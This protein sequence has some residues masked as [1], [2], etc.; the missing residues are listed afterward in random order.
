MSVGKREKCCQSLTA[1]FILIVSR[2][3][4]F[5]GHW[6]A[7]FFFLKQGGDQHAREWRN[8]KDTK[9]RG[10]RQLTRWGAVRWVVALHHARF[11]CGGGGGGKGDKQ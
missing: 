9:G 10:K 5:L 8:I 2:R 7:V 4:F 1:I 3:G 6:R 11:L